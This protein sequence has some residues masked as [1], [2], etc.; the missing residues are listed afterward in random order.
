VRVFDV[1]EHLHRPAQHDEH[2]EP[3]RLGQRVTEVGADHGHR[4]AEDD[5]GPMRP[6]P[7]NGTR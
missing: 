2:V 1:V 6:G 5:E 4:P 7:S 3:R